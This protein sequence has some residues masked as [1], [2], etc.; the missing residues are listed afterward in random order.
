MAIDIEYRYSG[1]PLAS[2][3]LRRGSVDE[4][5]IYLQNLVKE[6]KSANIDASYVSSFA[7]EGEKNMVFINDRPIVEILDGLEIRPLP[8]TEGDCFVGPNFLKVRRREEDWDGENVEDL[9]DTLVK[10]AI[11]K[12]FSERV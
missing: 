6:M 10:N 3:G 7:V 1:R 2:K 11:S 9:S 4:M 8:P 5:E 12:V